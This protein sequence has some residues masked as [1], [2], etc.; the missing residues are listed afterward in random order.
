MTEYSF[1]ICVLPLLSF[2]LIVF[3]FRW[4]EKLSSLFSIAMILASFLLSVIVLIET[5]GRHG[6][7]Y[8]ASYRFLDF[9]NFHLQIGI[10]VDALTAIMLVVVT[11]VGACVQIYSLGYMHN[12]PR[13][14]R[15]FAYLSLFLFSML[16][17]VLAN[18]F[19]MIFIFWELVGLTSYLLIGFWFEK[20]SAADACKKAFLTT[21]TG[22]LG[23]IVGLLTIGIYFGT[24]NYGEVFA[25]AGSGTIPA[26]I[27]TLAAVGVFCGAVGKSAQFPLHVWLPDAMEGPTPVSAL[28]HAA[29]MVAAGVYLVARS[30]ALFAA[31][32]EAALVV[33][34]IGL[35]TSFIAATIALTQFDIK[36][37]LAYST[38]S[39]LGYMIMALGLFGYDTAHA[40]HSVGYY[41]GTFH[42]MTHAFFKGLLFLGAGSVIHA[43][44]TNDIREMGGLRTKMPRT[45]YTFM[46]A[47]LSIAGI[48]PL[49][50]FW[51]K[52]EIVAATLD[53]PVFFVLTLAIAFMTAFY[54]WRLCFLTFFGEPRDPHRFA[55]AHESPANM[56]Y[57]LV[58][59][60]VLAVSAGWVGLPM[61]WLT[62]H[63]I[64][65]FLYFGAEAP[66]HHTPAYWLMGVSLLVGL[67]GIGLAAA[68]YYW[69]KISA[70][71][72]VRAVR[73]VHAFLYHKWYFDELYFAA[74]VNPLSRFA[75]L[76]W[77]FDAG[78]VDGAVNGT[79]WL[80]ILWADIKQWFD[81]WIVDGA[82]NGAGWVVSGFG[83]LLRYLQ[84]GRPQFYALTIGAVLVFAALAKLEANV[85]GA[86]FPYLTVIFGAGVILL[87][88][89]ARSGRDAGG[90][91]EP[92]EAKEFQVTVEEKR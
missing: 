31:S 10:L 64:A 38:V 35:T 48:F 89:F 16:G 4:N 3:F 44:H 18:N 27:L 55:H 76:L 8:E 2:L 17:L 51:S 72:V 73:P 84:S 12:D 57:P 1:L 43:V 45:S 69:K 83:G 28:I 23:F 47:S 34:I 90:P 36:R 42:L 91:D 24:F 62:G 81:T 41:A 58:F 56:T 80:T 39:Q 21:R 52:D 25:L 85:A 74:I 88:L 79:A 7:A 30:M 26:G 22:D 86:R 32:A 29:T 53:H 19:F 14:S 37:I 20:K 70:D 68:M 13:F 60:A 40:R 82:V 6:A 71:S 65:S 5:I 54:M 50:G 66:E 49:A 78:I 61:E 87:G 15:F 77:K 92:S 59:L 11:T 9:P 75:G 67:A 46:I 63:G 33:A